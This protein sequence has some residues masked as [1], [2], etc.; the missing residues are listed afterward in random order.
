MV[1]DGWV[2]ITT[3]K[4]ITNCK[5]C[6]FGWVLFQNFVEVFKTHNLTDDNVLIAYYYIIIQC[7]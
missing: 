3:R 6:Y 1:G 5:N 2:F 4:L 7:V